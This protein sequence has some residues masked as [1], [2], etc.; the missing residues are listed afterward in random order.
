VEQLWAIAIVVFALA[1]DCWFFGVRLSGFG[2]WSKSE[3]RQS[4]VG[5]IGF[6]R[7]SS[8]VNLLPHRRPRYWSLGFNSHIQSPLRPHFFQVSSIDLS[9]SRYLKIQ[10]HSNHGS[11]PI[12]AL[13]W[14]PGKNWVLRRWDTVAQRG[15]RRVLGK[16]GWRTRHER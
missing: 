15:D 13:L 3:S 7:E 9:P 1:L 4:N 2:D 16:K 14:D 8:F 5:T 12:L 6:P 10:V 11:L